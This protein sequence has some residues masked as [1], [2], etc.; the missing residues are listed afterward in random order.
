MFFWVIM[1]PISFNWMSPILIIMGG[2]EGYITLSFIVFTV[3]FLSSFVVGRAYCAYGCQWGASQE[4][5]SNL[6]PKNLDPH[7]KNRNRKIKYVIFIFWIVLIILGPILMGGYINSIN[8]FYPNRPDEVNTIISFSNE[9]I[10]QLIFYFGILGSVI[11]LFTIIGG[12]RSFCNYACPMAVLG[13]IGTKIKNIIKYPSLHL[14]SEPNKCTNCKLCT[15]SC[16]MDLDVN[17]MVQSRDMYNS[18]CILCGNC[19]STCNN[20]VLHYAWKWKK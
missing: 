6:L 10:G 16:S 15:K 4:V 17:Q 9:A 13:I 2:F 1:L 19:V 5:L 12:K 3:W 8:I 7:K 20:D 11:I 14:E 18:D